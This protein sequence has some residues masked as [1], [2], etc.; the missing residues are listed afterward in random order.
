MV[1]QSKRLAYDVCAGKDVPFSHQKPCADHVTT[2]G[3]NPYE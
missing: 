3:V 1:I 2:R